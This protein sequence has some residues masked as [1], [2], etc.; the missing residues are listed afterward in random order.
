V[1]DPAAADAVVAILTRH[2]RTAQRIGHAVADAEKRV[3]IP[4]RN[5][6]GRHKQFRRE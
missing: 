4:S 3:R 2:G 1:V 6:V 5:L